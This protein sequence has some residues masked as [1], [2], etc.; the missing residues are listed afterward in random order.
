MTAIDPQEL[1]GRLAA[2]A[3]EQADLAALA[4]LAAAGRLA[5]VPPREQTRQERLNL[6]DA[7]IRDSHR[8][9]PGPPTTAAKALAEA[10]TRYLA[11]AWLRERDIEHLASGASDQRR[12]LHRIARLNEGRSLAW[13]QVVNI[14]DGWRRP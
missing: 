5:V 6:R 4:Q 13:R 8:L 11:S 10:L 1:L 7:A 3:V 14:V 2:G 12:A 9:F